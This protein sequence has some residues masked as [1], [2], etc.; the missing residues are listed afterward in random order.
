[1]T[2]QIHFVLDRSGSMSDGLNDYL[3]GF[4]AFL[5][6][7][8]KENSDEVLMS[9][10]QFDHD[11]EIVYQD[12]PLKEVKKLTKDTFVP[13]G[14]TALFDAI[15]ETLDNIKAK[16]NESVIIVVL[17][18]GEENA[19]SEFTGKRISKMISKKKELGWEFVYL[20]ANQDAILEGSKLGI[21]NQSSRTFQVDKE[22]IEKCFSSLSQ[23][24]SDYRKT[25]MKKR[26]EKGV[27]FAN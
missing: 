23:A 16:E 7:Q 17:T 24:V 5:D 9:L 19:S 1:M 12:V 13:R 26:K 2:T 25:P 6:S 10:Y 14:R 27:S 11:Y 18:D 3:G 15:G 22:G 8:S 4:N 20:G 21:N